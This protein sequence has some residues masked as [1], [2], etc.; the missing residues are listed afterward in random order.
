MMTQTSPALAAEFR[1]NITDQP[2]LL[3]VDGNPQGLLGYAANNLISNSVPFARLIHADDQDIA[4]LLFSYTETPAARVSNLRLRQAN[5]RIRC[6]RAIFSKV[7]AVDRNSL[8]LELRLEDAKSLGRTLDDARSLINIKAMMDNTDDFIFFKDRNH[9]FTGA[10]Q[11]LIKLCQPAE[12]WTDLLGQTDYDVFPEHYADIYYR[13]EKQIFAGSPAVHEI[14]EYL[15]RD[16]KTGWVDNRKYPIKDESG[17]IIGLYGIARDI[18]EKIRIE[19]SLKQ[20]HDTLQLILDYA[21]IGIWLQN[22]QGHMRFV[23]KAFCQATGISEAQFLATPHYAQLISEEFRQQCLASDAKALASE[24]VSVTRQSLP[25][26]DGQVHDLRV[27]KAVKR[28]QNKLPVAL[29]GLSM[30]I[31]DELKRENALRDSEQRFRTLFE[32]TPN[33]AVQGYDAERNVI[34]WNQASHDLYG[35]SK[36]EALG[37]KLEDLIIPEAMRASLIAAITNWINGGA[38]IPPGELSLRHKNGS[39]I[40]VLSSHVLQAGSNGLE[41]YCIDIDLRARK[42]AEKELEQY[43]HHLETLVEERTAELLLAKDAAETANRAKST[44]LANMS[45]ELRT[46]ISGII[47][48]TAMAQRRS[49]EPATRD[50]LNKIDQ[51][52]Q[53][54]LAVINNILDISKIEADRL[55]LSKENFRL[56]EL[57][58]SVTGMLGVKVAEKGLQL[59]FDIAPEV[60]ALTVCGDALRI[61]QILLNFTGNAIKF[62]ERGGIIL[63]ADII[64]ENKTGVLLRFAVEDSGIGISPEDQQRLFSPFE[65]ADGSSARK[66]GGSGLGLAISRRL[67][68]IM[69]GEVGVDSIVGQGSTFWFTVRLAKVLQQDNETVALLAATSKVEELKA[70]FAGTRILLAEDEPIN[71]EVTMELLKDAGLQVDLAADGEIALDLALRWDYALIL[72]DIQ[73]PRLNGIDATMAIRTL[74]NHAETP[75]LAM[76][77][78]AFEEDRQTCLDAGMNDHIGKPVMPEVLYGVLL[79]WLLK[80][81]AH[82]A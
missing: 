8:I 4:E 21:P 82:K 45:H 57:F 59:H 29:V 68:N 17:E 76:T 15:D 72:M 43:R 9:V 50:C 69:H 77:A 3:H 25:F 38:S 24:G 39:P 48:M 18:T 80:S 47:G 62:S 70:K 35:Y 26:V 46:P 16:G 65:Q 79:K 20:E 19:Q 54:L 74:P 31:S 78:N 81:K 33:V 66:Y 67:A 58:D 30:D 10:S 51:S 73:M 71:Q 34:F 6:C 44:F 56:R 52:S 41:M 1:F 2:C 63:R 22:G 28:D 61:E 60:A 12:H 36:Q 27:I 75:I 23:N 40:E 11:T 7:F 42:R 64:D 55:V 53:H 49:G 13:L 32:N 14:Q 37:R 5:G